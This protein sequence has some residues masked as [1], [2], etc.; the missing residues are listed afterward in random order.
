MWTAALQ[1][2]DCNRRSACSVPGYESHCIRKGAEAV[3]YAAAGLALAALAARAAGLGGGARR[4]AAAAVCIVGRVRVPVRREHIQ[5]L[6]RQCLD[7]LMHG[8]DTAASNHICTLRACATC[9]L[10]LCSVLY[11]CSQSG[12]LATAQCF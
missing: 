8:E 5:V 4:A 6:C 10:V 11:V 7:S 9:A 3:R 2:Y 1:A 12:N